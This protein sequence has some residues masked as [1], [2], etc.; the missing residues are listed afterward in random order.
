[1]KEL[2]FTLVFQTHESRDLSIACLFTPCLKW[3]WGGS[4]LNVPHP[5]EPHYLTG[6]FRELLTLP[7]IAPCLPGLGS[8]IL[9][10][11]HTEGHGTREDLNR[12]VADIQNAG[13]GVKCISF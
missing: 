10:V 1:M 8:A 3:V 2:K 7:A 5:D 13:Y 11:I 6:D 12:L 9:L 4:T